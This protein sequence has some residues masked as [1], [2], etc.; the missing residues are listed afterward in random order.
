MYALMALTLVFT[1]GGLVTTRN[2][3]RSRP[4][5]DEGL[6]VM[7]LAAVGFLVTFNM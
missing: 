4:F 6:A 3:T 2:W 1:V 7:A 5:R